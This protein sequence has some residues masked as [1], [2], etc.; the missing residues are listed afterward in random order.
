MQTRYYDPELGRFISAD[1]IEYL[2]PETLGGLNLYAYCGN[3]PIRETDPTGTSW[4]SFW[5]DVGDWFKDTGRKIKNFFVNDVYDGVIKPAVNWITDTAA[6][7]V[8]NFFTN[9]IPDFFV[10]TFWNDWIVDKFWNTFCV[11][12]VW[13]TFCVDWVWNTFCVDWVAGVAWP[14]LN[15][16]QWYQMLAKN[17]VISLISTG[18]SAGIGAIIGAIIGACGGPVSAAAGAVVGAIVGFVC[19]TFVGL[20]WDILWQ[21]TK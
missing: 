10:N 11:D 1:S 17:A 6:P 13:N 14:W 16:D 4:N 2:D 15:G 7:A 19:G 21:K 5:Q 8:G 12:W 3:N 18:L 20:I 9:T